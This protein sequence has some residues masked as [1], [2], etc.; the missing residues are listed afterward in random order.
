MY[1]DDHSKQGEGR[2]GISV[3]ELER[4]RQVESVCPA[5]G[6]GVVTVG[7]AAPL[8]YQA[9]GGAGGGRLEGVLLLPLPRHQDGRGVCGLTGQAP[10]DGRGEIWIVADSFKLG[11]VIIISLASFPSSFYFYLHENK[12]RNRNLSILEGGPSGDFLL[13]L[14]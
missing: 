4:I 9:A 6:T 13:A 3:D 1:S 11:P 2:G 12:N 7:H 10:R 8:G 14:E 5:L